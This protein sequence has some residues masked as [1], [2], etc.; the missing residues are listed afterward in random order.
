MVASKLDI[1]FHPFSITWLVEVS[2]SC[3]DK[4]SI[5]LCCWHILCTNRTCMGNISP[6]SDHSHTFPSG[7]ITHSLIHYNDVIMSALASQI[8]GVSMVYSIVCSGISKKTSKLHATGLCG[9]NSQLTGEF[10][11]QRASSEENVFI[12]WRHHVS[13]AIWALRCC[14]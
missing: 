12:L 10:P 2:L 4:I 5:V 7:V 3:G 9:G 1:C 14:S 8:T 11:A 6:T 13:R